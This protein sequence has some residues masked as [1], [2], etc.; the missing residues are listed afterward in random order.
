MIKGISH[1]LLCDY[2]IKRQIIDAELKTIYSLSHV[3]AILEDQ[4]TESSLSFDPV[5]LGHVHQ[6]INKSTLNVWEVLDDFIYII[7]ASSAIKKGSHSRQ[8]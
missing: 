6:L 4:A 8:P 7:E 2:V 5:A 3:L 1:A